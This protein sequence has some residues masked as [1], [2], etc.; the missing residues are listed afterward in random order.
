MENNETVRIQDGFAFTF[1][2]YVC[3][4]GALALFGYSYYALYNF[5]GSIEDNW[6]SLK[7]KLTPILL[8]IGFG[9]I[10]TFVS[11][12]LLYRDNPGFFIY[13][14]LA[15]LCLNVGMSVSAFCGIIIT[16]SL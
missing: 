8:Y 10:L 6:D 2:K 15:I 13:F 5:I 16:K 3:I 1:V 9:T 4:F 12:Y 7:P 11:A 14:I